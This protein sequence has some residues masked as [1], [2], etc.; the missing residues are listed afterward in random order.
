MG[1]SGF[2][3]CLK[4]MIMPQLVKAR[5]TLPLERC[6][7]YKK[8]RKNAKVQNCPECFGQYGV[9]SMTA[10]SELDADVLVLSMHDPQL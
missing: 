1:L 3:M 2:S 7:L 10:S 6:I 9:V 5:D 4:N 8:R